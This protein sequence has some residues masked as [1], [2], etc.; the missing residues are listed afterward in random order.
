MHF[1]PGLEHAIEFALEQIRK[2]GRDLGRNA[3][4]QKTNPHTYINVA[5][6]FNV[7]KTALIQS[8]DDK[9]LKNDDES[10]G[11]EN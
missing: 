8:M 3:P 7:M 2:V 5:H 6:K 11:P 4:Y 1:K 10:A 9:G